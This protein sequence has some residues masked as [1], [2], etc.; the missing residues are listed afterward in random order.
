MTSKLK[1]VALSIIA[2]RATDSELKELNEV[3]KAIDKNNDGTLTIAEMRN[4]I[5]ATGVGASDEDIDAILRAIDTD[6]SGR[7]DYTEFIAATME[8]KLY[9]YHDKLLPC[10]RV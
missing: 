6:G 4:G 5:Q 1:K 10:F 9:L 2:Q 7:I 8:I 3:W